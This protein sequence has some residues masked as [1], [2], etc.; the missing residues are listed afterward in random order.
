MG[1]VVK[2]FPFMGDGEMVCLVSARGLSAEVKLFCLQGNGEIVCLAGDL[3]E[4]VELILFCLVGDCGL[5]D[6]ELAS[7]VRSSSS[8]ATGS[9]LFMEGTSACSCATLGPLWGEAICIT[10]MELLMAE[11]VASVT[12]GPTVTSDEASV[13]SSIGGSC[14]GAPFSSD[15]ENFGTMC[16]ETLLANRAAAATDA[17]VDSISRHFCTS[18]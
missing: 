2:L 1:T 12:D 14:S 5:Y 4:G 6:L 9:T 8:A 13:S 3:G 17:K 16:M 15:D 7:G 10:S 18:D 11:P